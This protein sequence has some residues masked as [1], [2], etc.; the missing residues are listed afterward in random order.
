MV[1]FFQKTFN[2]DEFSLVTAS[3]IISAPLE[4]IDNQPE[5]KINVYEPRPALSLSRCG[6]RQVTKF[7]EHHN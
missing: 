1:L 3:P 4:P 7:Q 5:T 2:Y 6:F